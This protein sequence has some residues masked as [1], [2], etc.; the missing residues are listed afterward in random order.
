MKS[1]LECMSCSAR[2]PLLELHYQCPDCSSLL[3]VRHDLTAFHGEDLRSRF[4]ARLGSLE[5]PYSSGVWRYKE[6]VWPGIEN[7][8]IISHPE[9]NTNLY[10]PTNLKEWAGVAELWFKHEGENPTG[11]FKDRG[12]TSAITHARSVGAKRLACASTG[13]TAASLAS[14]AARAEKRCL[15]FVHSAGV[16][17]SKQAQMLDYGANVLH[18]DMDFD[19]NLNLVRQLAEHGYVYLANSLNPLRL[20]GQK[21]IIFELLQHLDWQVPDWIIAPGGNLGNIAAFG[22]AL[23]ELRSLGMLSDMPRLAV[24][25]AAG[26]NPFYCS[27]TQGYAPIEIRPVQTIASAIRIGNPINFPKAVR[28]LRDTRGIVEEVTDAQILDAK[29]VLGRHGIGCE[30]ASAATLA[31]LIKLREIGIIHADDRVACIL[32][33]H[34]LKD[35]QTSIAYHLGDLPGVANDYLNSPH[36]VAGNLPAILAAIEELEVE[37]DWQLHG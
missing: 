9:G 29:A 5:Y 15:I 8:A 30:P 35:V 1:W 18:V 34:G 6:L 2:L 20:E 32:T 31:G 37:A 22:K 10:G 28:A 11:S 19:G 25:Q 13:N 24:I 33:G 12:M 27:Y 4:D 17:E 14:Y 26:A 23:V 3:D 16:S 7:A 21:T 36:R